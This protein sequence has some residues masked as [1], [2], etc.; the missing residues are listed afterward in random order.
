MTGWVKLHKSIINW[1]WYS[2]ANTFRVFMHLLLSVNHENKRYMG[3]DVPIGSAVSGRH[4][5]AK[6]LGL[7]EQSVR[8]ALTKLKSTSE[9]TI[10]KTNKFSIISIN[11]WSKYQTINQQSNIPSTNNQPTI[12]QQSTTPKEVKKKEVK[13]ITA[14]AGVSSEVWED[15]V[16]HRKSMDAPVSKTALNGIQREAIKAGWALEEAL[17]ECCVRGW[18]GFKSE[19]VP[20]K[21]STPQSNMAKHLEIMGIK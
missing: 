14:P 6:A 20:K 12:N 17:R 16:E 2:D 1:E 9:I 21:T 13:T 8:T 10:K 15:F 5:L 11:N 3:H 7:S 19:W 18:R 4:S